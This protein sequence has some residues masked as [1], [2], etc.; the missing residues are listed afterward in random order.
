MK[1]LLEIFDDRPM[2]NVLATDTFRPETTVFLCADAVA[3]DKALHDSYRRYF[4]RRG[5]S[6][7]V[8]FIKTDLMA[9]GPVINTLRRVTSDYEDCALDITGGSDAVLFACGL[10][11]AEEP[12][13][14]FTFS[15]RS[16]RFYN[17]RNAGF[18]ERQPI[19]LTYSVSDVFLMAG[20]EINVVY[21]PQIRRLILILRNLRRY[22]K[23][24]KL[25]K[26]KVKKKKNKQI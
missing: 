21:H 24:I 14:V 3:A 5:L 1:T 17:I 12:L 7:K 4:L 6:T 2:E 19:D 13:P 16:S 20:A 22:R 15:R 8:V 11:C 10:F 26:K 23:L 9:V 25:D 18:I